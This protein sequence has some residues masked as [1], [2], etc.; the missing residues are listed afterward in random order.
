[1]FRSTL[2]M[3]SLLVLTGLAL[4]IGIARGQVARSG[5]GESAQLAQELQQIASERTAL[6]AQNAKLQQ[7]LDAMR[8]ERDALKT[9]QQALERRARL[10]ES[11]VKQLAQS[12]AASR[13]AADK[14]IEQW[15]AQMQE[16]IAK[17]R[18]TAETLRSVESDRT[19][20]RQTLAARGRDLNACVDHNLALYRLDQEVLTRL[21]HQTVWSALARAEPF[22]RI[23]RNQLDNLVEGYRERADA[24]R[25]QAPAAQSDSARPSSALPASA[26]TPK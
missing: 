26:A 17:F 18:E 25:V 7:E 1:M 11:S 20:L 23:K 6:Q 8:K 10:S 9:A 5:G 16:L 14:T 19:A 22:T 3:S 13:Q 21:E 24:E 15:K 4:G 2:K 12:A